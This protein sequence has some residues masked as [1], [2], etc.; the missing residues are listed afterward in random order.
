MSPFGIFVI[1]TKNHKGMIFG[2]CYGRVWTQVLNGR[3]HFRL[4]SPVLQNSNHMYHLSQQTRIP[5]GIMNGVIVFTNEEANLSN[6]NCPFCFNVDDLYYYIMQFQN[7]ILNDRLI[8]RAIDRIDKVD[9]NSYM[10]RKKHIEYV[11]SLK[12]K[13]GY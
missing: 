7:S 10:N 4:Y 1:E 11:N 12:D 6:V 13:R 3:G 8:Q 2:D 9:T 5:I